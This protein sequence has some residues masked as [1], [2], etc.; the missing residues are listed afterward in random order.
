MFIDTLGPL[1]Q[2]INQ[3]VKNYSC[4]FAGFSGADFF[5]R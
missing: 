5:Y 1:F 3:L 2:W 4:S